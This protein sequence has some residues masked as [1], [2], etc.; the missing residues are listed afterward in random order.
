MKIAIQGEL[1]SFSHQAALRAVPNASVVP[2][3]VSTE[4][5]ERLRKGKV[6][7]I[8]IPIENTLAG[9]VVEHYDL[10]REEPVHIERE[11][12]IRIEHHVIGIAGSNLEEVRRIYSHPVAL[13]QCR[14]FFQQHSGIEPVAF[15]DTAGAVKNVIELR[16]NHSAAIASIQALSMYGGTVLAKNVE[17]N[18]ANFT[19]FLLVHS[20]DATSSPDGPHKLSLCCQVHHRTGALAIL[21]TELAATGGNLT[22]I[23]SRPVHGQPWHYY[24]FLDALMTDAAATEH[25]LGH[26]PGLSVTYRVLG[27]YS[28][29]P[30]F[31]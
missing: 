7:A 24:V 1:G 13:A 11:A 12:L 16:D 8:L 6:D 20:G 17:D 21:L 22:H 30:E 26:L 31:M 10:L 25:L 2:C 19:R 3:S 18:V 15:Y 9:S 28:P 27:R 4:V 29:A 23:Q 14:T 5:F